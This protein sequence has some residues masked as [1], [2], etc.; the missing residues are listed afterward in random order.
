M[1]FERIILEKKENIATITLNR[2]E[3]RNALDQ[4]LISEF[5]QAIEDIRKDKEIRVVV[6]TGAGTAFCSGVDIS[7]LA[8]LQ[9][10]LSSELREFIRG[11]QKVFNSLEDMEKPIIAAVNGH[12]I[13]G[14]CDLALACDIRIASENASFGEFYVKGRNHTRSGRNTKIA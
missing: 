1:D 8:P 4:K 3:A 12:A 14:G 7:I 2:P 10:M 9:G 11:W 5:K 6:I 13:G